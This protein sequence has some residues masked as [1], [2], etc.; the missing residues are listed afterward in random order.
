MNIVTLALILIFLNLHQTHAQKLR[1]VI[2][3]GVNFSSFSSKDHIFI[4][5]DDIL[6]KIKTWEPGFSAGYGLE[7]NVSSSLSLLLSLEYFKTKGAFNTQCG[8]WGIPEVI[9][10]YKNVVSLHNLGL[11]LF[12][13]LKTSKR[14]KTYIFTGAGINV[15]FY[16][17][18]KIEKE[19]FDIT[20]GL[21]ET[22]KLTNERFEL[23]NPQNQIVGVPFYIGLGHTFK[24]NTKELFAE[25][26]YFKDTNK[27]IYN[28]Y[29]YEENTL[30]SVKRYGFNLKLGMYIK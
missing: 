16:A 12:I 29:P 18:R 10:T 15:I 5:P 27:W 3:G 7:Y 6:Q 26:Y 28:L 1:H 23:K 25:L 11:P 19:Y 20:T 2:Y 30:L 21:R 17:R 24:I 4:K 14:S 9:I 22:E 8:C 13:K